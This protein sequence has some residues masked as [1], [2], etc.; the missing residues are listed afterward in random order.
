M[1]LAAQMARDVDEFGADESI[2]AGASAGAQEEVNLDIFNALS[3]EDKIAFI[4][5]QS[6]IF[7]ED[8]DAG[9]GAGAGADGL[10]APSKRK[11][12]DGNGLPQGSDSRIGRG[13]KINNG[14]PTA[15]QNRKIACRV[16][17]LR[18]GL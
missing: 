12:G 11:A 13:C 17:G 5:D 10:I 6:T 15:K 16:G 9:A 3:T 2:A 8:D 18:G 14:L 7:S 4:V 1:F